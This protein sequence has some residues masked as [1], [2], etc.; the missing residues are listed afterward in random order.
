MLDLDPAIRW[1]LAIIAGGGAASL[2]QSATAGLRLASSAS[3]G[4]LGNP[5]LAA[6][7]TGGSVGLGVLAILLPVVAGA[8]VLILLV[9]GVR[10]IRR[11]IHRVSS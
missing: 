2:V 5:V 3:T 4:G 1:P 9:L 7:E 8:L 6:G 10:H 11:R